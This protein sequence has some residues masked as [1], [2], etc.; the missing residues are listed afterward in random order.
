MNKGARPSARQIKN[1]IMKTQVSTLINGSDNVVRNLNAE[2]YNNCPKGTSS[3][4]AGTKAEERSRV[5]EAVKA[6]NPDALH[7]NVRGVEMT[8]KAERAVSSGSLINYHASITAEQWLTITGHGEKTLQAYKF[9]TSFEFRV[10]ANMTAE[11]LLYARK[12][13]AAMWRTRIYEYIDESF[14]TIL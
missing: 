1:S 11:A 7:V 13:E 10:N 2:K 4:Y 9:E 12:S 6:E 3:A 8:L 14:V 5:A